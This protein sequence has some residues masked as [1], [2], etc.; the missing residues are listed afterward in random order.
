MVSKCANPSCS[1]PFR[2]LHQGRIFAV[3][4]HSP[5]RGNVSR[6]VVERYWLCDTCAKT[7]TLVLRNG[8]VL[9]DPLPAANKGPA[10][11]LCAT[12]N[13]RLPAA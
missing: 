9:L 4:P 1:A 6:A 8:G 13:Q 5:D 10:R 7:M 11:A 3:R 12:G 2:Y